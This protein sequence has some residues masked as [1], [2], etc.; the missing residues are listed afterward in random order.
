MKLRGYLALTLVCT[1]FLFCD[2]WQ[3][4]VVTL[5]VTLRPSRRTQILASWINFM[6]RLVMGGAARIGGASLPVPP[7]VVPSGPGV[8]IVM[9]H[10]SVLDIPLV[11]KTV[12]GA[13]PRIITRA[14]YHR[15][16]PLIS[17]MVRL[18]Q[19]PVVDPSANPR[20]LISSMKEMERAA[21]ESE[22]PMAIFPE[23]TRSRDG[24][25]GPFKKRGLARILAQREWRVYVFVADGFWEAAK[26]KDFLRGVASIEGKM[27]YLGTAAW[28]D[29]GADPTAF[30][31]EL[32]DRMIAGLSALRSETAVR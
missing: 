28:T 30:I 9:N 21:R 6:A 3:R 14:R 32:R 12:D 23:G 11:V 22:V 15:F 26:I 13:Y 24:S 2:L 19:Y 17:H 4:T 29:P 10:Q 25:I 5:A 31:E 16:I 20:A 8:L 1:A 18:Y 27:A 7:R